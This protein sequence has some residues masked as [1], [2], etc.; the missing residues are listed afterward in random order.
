MKRKVPRGQPRGSDGVTTYGAP[1][2]YDAVR[3]DRVAA[4]GKRQN[5]ELSCGRG[6]RAFPPAPKSASVPAAA[7]IVDAIHGEDVAAHPPARQ[8]DE[9]SSA[10]V[11]DIY[12]AVAVAAQ[13]G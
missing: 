10:K 3:M 9:I 8:L 2:F 4:A 11:I 7:D 1:S 5:Y 13:I 12:A 6:V